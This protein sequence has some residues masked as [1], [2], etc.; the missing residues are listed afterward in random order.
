MVS[1]DTKV[2]ADF[3]GYDSNGNLKTRPNGTLAY[4]A[5]NRLTSITANGATTIYTY[6][7]GGT[8]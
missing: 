5:E 3:Y 8:R 4:D 7:G 2:G 6:D 1:C